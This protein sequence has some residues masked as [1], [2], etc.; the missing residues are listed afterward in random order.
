MLFGNWVA[1]VKVG[2]QQV[3]WGEEWVVGKE[4]NPR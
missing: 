1:T 2:G 4:N 3:W